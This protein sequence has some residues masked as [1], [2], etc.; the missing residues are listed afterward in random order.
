MDGGWAEFWRFSIYTGVGLF[1]VMS[2]WVIIAGFGDIKRM[3][4][5]LQRQ[6]DSNADDDVP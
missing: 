1:A 5:E 4:A 3:F 6:R 2:V